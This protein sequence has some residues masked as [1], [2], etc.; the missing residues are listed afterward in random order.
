VI[1]WT[2]VD[3]ELAVGQLGIHTGDLIFVHSSLGFLGPSSVEDVPR[4]ILNVLEEAVSP[5]GAVFFPAFTYSVDSL[6]LPSHTEPSKHMGALAQRAFK[7]G[8]HAS[9]DPI[10]RTLAS[11]GLGEEITNGKFEN[12]SFGPGSLFCELVARNIKI[13]NIS[14]GSGSTLLHEIEHRLGVPYRFEKILDTRIADCPSCPEIRTK[15]KSY[16]RDLGDPDSEADFSL[17]SKMIRKE[18]FWSRSLLGLSGITSYSS[19]DAII[20]LKDQLA[21]YPDLLIKR[22][23]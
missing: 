5:G 20:F 4:Q 11:D 16:V 17:F 2:K 8:Y 3:L 15:W 19:W 9:R 23:A 12:R 10:F 14:T 6:F 22:G 21:L 13:V 7:D 18:P 1:P